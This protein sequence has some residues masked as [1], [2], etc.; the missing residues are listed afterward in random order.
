MIRIGYEIECHC[1][2]PARYWTVDLSNPRPDGSV[3]IDLD[4]AACQ[5]DF[6][7]K[8]CGCITGTGDLDRE[9]D[10][11]S[12]CQTDEDLEPDREESAA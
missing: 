5:V 7:C 2:E 9:V 4:M 10:P 12:S 6:E 8:S 3:L 1:G 11:D